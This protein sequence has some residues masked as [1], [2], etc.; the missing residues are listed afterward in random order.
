MEMKHLIVGLFASCFLIACS[1]PEP[2]EEESVAQQP[3]AMEVAEEPVA[4]AEMACGC[5]EG[6]CDCAPDACD[7]APGECNCAA[8]ECACGAA[9]VDEVA[10]AC[11]CGAGCECGEGEC[12]CGH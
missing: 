1:S 9:E 2:V 3:A 4:V 6:A 12:T 5:E 8:G 11:D 10:H 7:C